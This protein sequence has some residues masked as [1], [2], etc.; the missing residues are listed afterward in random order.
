M[1]IKMRKE[2]G[3]NWNKCEAV[4]V[5]VKARGK[6]QQDVSEEVLACNLDLRDSS[7]N[8]QKFAAHNSNR[9]IKNIT[10]PPPTPTPCSGAA[11]PLETLLERVADPLKCHSNHCNASL[12]F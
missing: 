11:C 8:S 2:R 4:P 6:G 12:F 1:Q 7:C 5:A 9:L 3:N 10:R